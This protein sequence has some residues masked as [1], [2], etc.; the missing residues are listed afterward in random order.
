M[1]FPSRASHISIPDIEKDFCYPPWHSALFQNLQYPNHSL[2]KS[3]FHNFLT[4][5]HI[6]IFSS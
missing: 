4:N 1:V 6:I 2:M 5:N 3:F